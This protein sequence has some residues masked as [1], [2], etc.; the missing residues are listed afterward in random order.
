MVLMGE[1]GRT[2]K[3]NASAAAITGRGP[4]RCCWPVVGCAAG[5][6]SARRMASVSSLWI[7][8]SA[9]RTWPSPSWKLLG[10]DPTAELMTPGGRPM[11]IMGE[12]SFIN[13]LV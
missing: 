9:R 11:K 5:K 10:V 8:R 12:G 7:G 1:F 3:L 6:S 4:A 2:P 13:E